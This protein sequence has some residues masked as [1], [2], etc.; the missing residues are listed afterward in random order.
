MSDEGANGRV[1]SRK[2]RD[3]KTKRPP[4][5]AACVS[6]EVEV[7]VRQQRAAGPTG[8]SE[9]WEWTISFIVFEGWR[10]RWSLS[11]GERAERDMVGARVNPEIVTKAGRGASQFRA[12]SRRSAPTGRD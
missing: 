12:R 2:C 8:G 5:R 11:R 3:R 7:R 10:L 4:E 6:I 1:A 9:L